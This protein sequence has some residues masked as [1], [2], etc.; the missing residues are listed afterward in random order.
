MYWRANANKFGELS[1]I[2]AR[3]SES[4]A[5]LIIQCFRVHDRMFHGK[6]TVETRRWNCELSDSR[7]S[8]T[9]PVY[10]DLGSGRWINE[11]CYGAGL[12]AH[13][14]QASEGNRPWSVTELL[15]V[16]LCRIRHQ[17]APVSRGTRNVPNSW[18]R[19]RHRMSNT[20]T[21]RKR[22]S[23]TD[24]DDT[25]ACASCLY[26]VLHLNLVVQSVDHQPAQQLR[27]EVST[28]GRHPQSLLGDLLHI[29]YTGRHHQGN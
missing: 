29:I 18:Q 4:N 17:T 12:E 11:L 15:P 6:L 19:P 2:V 1:D 27:V 8:V 5:N 24:R 22:V 13:A 9:N 28:L 23:P 21:T 25:L 10:P 26:F 3:F 20:S 14:E 16:Q 7:C